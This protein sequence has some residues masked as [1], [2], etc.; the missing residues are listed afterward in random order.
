MTQQLKVQKS[1]QNTS[2]ALWWKSV[3]S[4]QRELNRTMRETFSNFM[5]PSLMP[6]SLWETEE[7]MFTTLQRNTHRVFS[8]L[9][10]NRQM[11][12]PWLTGAMT[13]PYVDIIE[14]GS[15]FRI[16]ADVPGLNAKDLEVSIADSAITIKGERSEE[17]KEEDDTYIRRECHCGAFSRTIALPEEADIEKAT[18]TFDQNV[19]TVEVPKKPE[20]KNKSRKLKIEPAEISGKAEPKGKTPSAKE[21]KEQPKEA[22][23]QPELL[24]SKREPAKPASSSSQGETVSKDNKPKVA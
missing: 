22:A 18:A 1:A 16:K 7:D 17:K 15:K 11:S 2:D 24:A 23:R 21:E 14:N 19:L 12:T 6:S 3:F 13:E 8:E 10:N 5:Q 4:L 9:F 20:A